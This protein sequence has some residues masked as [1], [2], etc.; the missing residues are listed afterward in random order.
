VGNLEKIKTLARTQLS[1][2][3]DIHSTNQGLKEFLAL[4]WDSIKLA[5]LPSSDGDLGN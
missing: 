4:I 2:L 3:L 5:S 1:S